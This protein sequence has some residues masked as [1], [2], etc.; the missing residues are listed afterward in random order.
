MTNRPYERPVT[1]SVAVT[2]R[3]ADAFISDAPDG[4]ECARPA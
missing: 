4:A 2:V 3:R 1:R